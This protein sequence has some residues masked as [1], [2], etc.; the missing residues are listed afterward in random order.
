MFLFDWATRL[1][2]KDANLKYK[3]VGS[4]G[5][6]REPTMLLQRP[7]QLPAHPPHGGRPRLI[8]QEPSTES[9]PGLLH[10][11]VHMTIHAMVTEGS[12]FEA[13]PVDPHSRPGGHN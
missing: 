1:T 3:T 7:S 6:S 9:P 2:L 8:H 4:P 5:R 11:R 13:T 10:C 12:G